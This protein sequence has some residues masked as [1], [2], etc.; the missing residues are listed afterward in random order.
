MASITVYCEGKSGSHDYDI[1]YKVTDGLNVTLQPIG[2][3][4]GANAIMKFIEGGTT[5]SDFYLFFRDRDF[6]CPVSETEKLY[7]DGNRTYYSY[8]TTIENY[9]FDVK[10]FYTFLQEKKLQDKYK[11]HSEE[12]VQ[13]MFIEIAKTIKDYQA[14]RHTLG[15]LRTS[16]SFGTTWTTGSGELPKE[17]DLNSCKREAWKLIEY[18]KKNANWT[19]EVF[20]ATLQKYLDKFDN[21]FFDNLMFFIFY[22]GKDFAKAITNKLEGFPIEEYYKFAKEKFDYTKFEDLVELRKIIETNK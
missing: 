2:G 7:F 18:A 14:V 19:E 21:V 22:Q 20:Q 8:R 3:V 15:E 5:Q 9:L 13:N 12:K 4:R 16:I 11:L 17:L 1:L 10:V 6:D